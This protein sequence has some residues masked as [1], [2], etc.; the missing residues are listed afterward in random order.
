MIRPTKESDFDDLIAIATASGLFE[1]DQVEMLAGML[2]SPSENDVWFT[3][4]AE[5]VPVGVA[6]L[7]PEKMTNGT[8]NLLFIAVHPDHQRQ[9][10]GKSILKHV[11]Q[12]LRSNGERILLVET[13]GLDSFDYVRSFY[14]GDG[15]ENEA[16]VRDFYDVGVDK[17]IFR[18][19]L[20]E[21]CG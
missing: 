20:T 17:I 19:S 3:D 12:W 4:E 21:V 16:R 1:P 9:G 5:S 2:R 18:K 14:V 11:Q 15:F 6:H 8:W 10:R 13:A 7:A